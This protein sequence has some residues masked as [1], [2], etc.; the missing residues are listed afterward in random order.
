MDSIGI[1]FYF[2]I[3]KHL[4]RIGGFFSC[5]NG[6]ARGAKVTH[7]LGL[8]LI[9]IGDAIVTE[10]GDKKDVDRILNKW[11]NQGRKG[12]LGAQ[13]ELMDIGYDEMAKL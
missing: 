8:M 13:C 10:F 7:I 6:A 1:H 2:W 9:D 3:Y 12:V 5:L 4:R 11:K